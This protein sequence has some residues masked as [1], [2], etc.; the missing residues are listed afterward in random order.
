MP[1]TFVFLL[2]SCCGT[3]TLQQ[4][5]GTVYDCWYKGNHKKKMNV[6]LGKWWEKFQVFYRKMKKPPRTQSLILAV[7]FILLGD[8]SN[9]IVRWLLF[10]GPLEAGFLFIWTFPNHLSFCLY[11]YFSELGW[12]S[13]PLQLQGVIGFWITSSVHP[14]LLLCFTFN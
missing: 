2:H 8:G 3:R 12:T 7:D 6:D 10:G 13:C 1:W 11:L 14:S 5:L 4:E 9:L